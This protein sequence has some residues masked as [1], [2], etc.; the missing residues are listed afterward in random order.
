MTPLAPTHPG[1]PPP[2]AE[3]AAETPRTRAAL[4]LADLAGMP[5]T[6]PSDRFVGRECITKGEW[7]RRHAITYKTNADRSSQQSAS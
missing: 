3:P 4:R 5:V 7:E 2:L 6:F 1:S